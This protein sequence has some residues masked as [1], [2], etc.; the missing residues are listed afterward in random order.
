M[1]LDGCI[2]DLNDQ[3]LILSNLE[4]RECVEALKS[5]FDAILVGAQ[6]VRSDHPSLL[7]KSKEHRAA[8]L[9]NGLTEHPLKVTLTLSGNLDP[10]NRFF[11]DGEQDGEQNG[12]VEKLVYC[13]QS[14]KLTLQKQIGH[15]ATVIGLGGSTLNPH[16]LLADLSDRGVGRLMIEGGAAVNRLFLQHG[17]VDCLRVAIAPWIV[18]DARAPRVA[19]STGFFGESWS[20]AKLVRVQALGDR[21]VL[22]YQIEPR[23]GLCE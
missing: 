17:L 1:S 2:D 20:T 6:T 3:R 15:V 10:G 23:Q 21:V 5:S 19:A 4:D 18:G 7:T 9:L 16:H 14:L 13:P 22:D 8:R 12:G 11:Q